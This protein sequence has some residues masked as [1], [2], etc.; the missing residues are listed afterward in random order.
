MVDFGPRV[1]PQEKSRRGKILRGNVV[2][3]DCDLVTSD[4]GFTNA[5]KGDCT[6]GGKKW[7]GRGAL[8][9][10]RD[11]NKNRIIPEMETS[12]WMEKAHTFIDAEVLSAVR[13]HIFPVPK[14]RRWGNII[15]VP[16]VLVLVSTFP[17]GLASGIVQRTYR[18]RVAIA[19]R[20]QMRELAKVCWNKFWAKAFVPEA[21][22]G[23]Y[24]KT[25][26]LVKDQV[27]NRAFGVI[28][29]RRWAF[30][31]DLVRMGIWSSLKDELK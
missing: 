14:L 2:P 15:R 12:E 18:Q 21:K 1:Y 5:G 25:H 28:P 11:R 26:R 20:T 10:K 29:W 31:K 7:C 24:N 4:A 13:E 30:Y 23:K 17:L 16:I 19:S 8:L 6:C 27:R 9:G 3:G 22:V